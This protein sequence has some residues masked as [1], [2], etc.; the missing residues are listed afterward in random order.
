MAFI[1]THTICTKTSFSES[2]A[3]VSGA[4]F[5]SG[6]PTT[7]MPKKMAKKMICSMDMSTSELKM[8]LGTT[9]TKG[10]SGPE[11]LV[12]VAL[13]SLSFTHSLEAASSLAML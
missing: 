4:F 2:T 10:C 5:S 13:L 7:T 1:T 9:S 12:F 11:F 8:F 3:R 6:N